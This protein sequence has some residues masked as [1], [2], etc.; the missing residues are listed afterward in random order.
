M[1]AV[2]V[3]K[4]SVLI[5]SK[6]WLEVSDPRKV[7][8]KLA[9]IILRVTWLLSPHFRDIIVQLDKTMHILDDV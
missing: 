5:V 8:N 9:H 7:S 4:F 2:I 3:I 1:K 6:I